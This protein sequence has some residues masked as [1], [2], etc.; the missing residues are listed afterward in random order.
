MEASGFKK[1][2]NCRAHVFNILTKFRRSGKLIKQI[3]GAKLS[4]IYIYRLN[5]I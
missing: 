5:L 1:F 4:S 3:V 2:I